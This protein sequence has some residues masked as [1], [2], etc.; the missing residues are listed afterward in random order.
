MRKEKFGIEEYIDSSICLFSRNKCTVSHHWDNEKGETV[1]YKLQN[2]R[3]AHP[4]EKLARSNLIL[5]PVVSCFFCFVFFNY[6]FYNDFF[7]PK[8]LA[9]SG[10]AMRSEK[11][12]KLEISARPK[13][14]YWLK[15]LS[16]LWDS[17]FNRSCHL[18]F[19]SAGLF[20][21]WPTEN[22]VKLLPF[23]LALWG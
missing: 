19:C 12:Y 13:P 6:Y 23:G 20:L 3:Q 16:F 9:V 21:H 1:F 8:E 18:L 14:S 5:S 7:E 11:I 10:F 4:P 17:T 2:K 22:G 15:K